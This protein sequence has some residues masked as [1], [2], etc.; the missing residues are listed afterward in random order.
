MD[1][2]VIA[3]NRSQ[4][5]REWFEVWKKEIIEN[6]LELFI[7]HDTF[8]SRETQKLSNL[9]P[10]GIKARMLDHNDV[11]D[12]FKQYS[13]IIP[14]QSGACK[15]YAIYR[16]W[17][18]GAERIYCLDDD[19]LPGPNRY[20]ARHQFN[21]RMTIR[22]HVYETIDPVRPRGVPYL[23]ENPIMLSHGLWENVPDVDAATQLNGYEKHYELRRGPIPIGA[24]FPFCGMN[25]ACNREIIPLMYFGLHG[26][27]WP[28]DRFDD[29][30]CGFIAKKIM[31]HLGYAVNSGIP[32]IN[33]NRA[34]D[35]L[36]NLEKEAK[37]YQWNCDFY[38]FVMNDLHIIGNKVLDCLLSVA[39]Q[40]AKCEPVGYFAQ[41][42]DALKIWTSLFKE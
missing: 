34:S 21:L 6:A 1:A 9:F 14:Q 17:K 2:L 13:W 8:D 15:S 5:F 26:H 11:I 31:D 37:G 24:L 16:A 23:P 29:I 25:W 20:V 39:G 27:A 28:V 30:W 38:E 36:K 42:G 3:T 18:A 12:E 35:P 7:M 19:C 40:L 41:Y 4:N 32:Q 10:L 22:N 33:H